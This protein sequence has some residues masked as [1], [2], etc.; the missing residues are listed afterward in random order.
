MSRLSLEEAAHAMHG[1]LTVSDAHRGTTS[2]ATEVAG[3]SIDS[4]TLRQGD[5]FF[6]IVGPRV[7][8][9][10]FARQAAGQG[11]AA[12]VVAKG[13]PGRYP[14]APAVVRV[15]D[16]TRALQD[17]GGHV[18]RRSALKVIG[19]TGSAGKTTAKEMTGA[20]LDRRFRT[21]RSEGNLNN[22][23]G[24]PLTLLRMADK[25]E[26]AVLEMGMSYRGE[27][28][29]LV[30][31]ADPDVGV[32]L[33]VLPVHLEHFSS[34]AGIAAAKGEMFRG[35]RRDAVAVY[36][37]DDARVARLGRAF[38]G[39]SLP[40]GI[41]SRRAEVAAEEIVSL[42]LKG[43]RFTLRHGDAR[44]PV[45]LGL[46]GRHHVYNALAAAATGFACGLDA[47]DIAAGLAQ[48]RPAAMRGVLHRRQDG[49][50]I[51]DDSYNS[52]PAAME[53]AIELLS[54]T[55]PRGRRIL[56][57][58]DMLEL[59]PAA[60]RAHT[61]IGT[62]AARAGI[63]LLVA[64]GPLSRK[65]A[66]AAERPRPARV[67]AAAGR[68]RG[69]TPARVA[70]A[71]GSVTQVRHFDTSEEAAA[72]LASEARPGDLVLVKGSRGIRMERVVRALL[73]DSG[74]AATGPAAQHAPREN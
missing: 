31:I 15:G 23:W 65:M 25:S 69:A 29:R 11:A 26:A 51:L 74:S 9:H 62:L 19:I 56:A 12:V 59:G 40:Y 47:S 35:L 3:Y 20:V 30:E 73:G 28:A 61:R 52:N 10:D 71:P 66:A 16:T 18:R 21:H 6:A 49:A 22:A 5:L 67:A 34:I 33:N 32:I 17:L 70:A 7:D 57:A 60:A 43:T 55:E 58:G 38:K 63:D 45:R 68:R 24:L 42:G 50:E 54:E 64:V 37:A 36:N 27:I 2:G 46:P 8:G 72:F 39:R 1:R 4:R 13:G 14:E 48:V 41:A 53:R 44:A